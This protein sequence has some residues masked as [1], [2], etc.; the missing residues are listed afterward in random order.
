MKKRR[1]Y[2]AS[3]VVTLTFMTVP[4]LSDQKQ[5]SAQSPSELQAIPVLKNMSEYLAHAESYRV[6]IRDG[7]DVIQESGQKVEFGEFRIVTVSRSDRLRIEV[8]RSDGQKDLVIFDGKDMTIYTAEHNIY[9]ISSRQGTLN[10]AIKY[11]L[12]DL[13]IRMPLA[14]MFLSTLPSE[15]DNL[16]VSA[17][18]VE[19]T[20]IT[21]VPCDH[22]SVR[23]AGGVDLQVWIAQGSE[24]LPRRIV[25]T[26]KEENGQPQFSADLSNWNLA[27]DLSDA[28]FG[29]TPPNAVERIQYHAEVR[30]AAHSL[31]KGP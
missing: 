1:W 17:D 30:S 5:G 18:Y 7:Y 20:N 15:L 19:K 31:P 22:L 29:F 11:A 2:L 10:Q 6:T 28:P 21:D 25:L 14:L 26:Y 16:G 27:P 4:V 3:L 12:D 13:K 24:P 9:A 8:E 23:P